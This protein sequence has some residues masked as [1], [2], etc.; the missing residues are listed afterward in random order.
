[1]ISPAVLGS[2]IIEGLRWLCTLG[3][4]WFIL[5]F[6]YVAL[7]SM[8]YPFNLEW[9]EAQTMDVMQRVLDGKPVYAEPA[10]EYVAFIYTP[11]YY[12]VSAFVS[13]LT[14]GVD[15]LPARLVSI[16]STLGCIGLICAWIRKEQGSWHAAIIG[17]GLYMATYRLSGRWFDNARVDSLFMVLTL[18]GLY[19]FYH[20][21]G[22]KAAWLAS[23]LM[24]AGFFTKQAALMMILPLL[25]AMFFVDRRHALLT[26]AITGTLLL[27]GVALYH[28]LSDGWFT[29]FVFE[30]PSGHDI[31][32]PLLWNYWKVDLLPPLGILLVVAV[33]SIVLWGIDEWRRGLCYAALFVGF[34]GASYISR[35]HM[36]G[37]LNVLMP[38]HLALGLVAG[39]SFAYFERRGEHLVLA[40]LSLLLLFQMYGLLY[41][42]K[43]LIPTQKALETGNKFLEELSKIEGE[44]F[45]PELQFVQTRIGQK[46][47][48]LGM[49]AFDVLRS[50]LKNRRNV[51]KKLEKDITDVIV[52]GRFAAIMPGKLVI[53]PR[54][55]F[56]YSYR[57]H[58]EYPQ[59]FI[60]GAINFLRTDLY[61]RK[62]AANLPTPN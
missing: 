58:M 7:S 11:L 20:Y 19:V 16:L 47:Y 54:V 42:P 25:A 24:V 28:L 32:Y 36:Y 17:A 46:S 9:M 50:D 30:V 56:Y 4:L 34:V 40:V 1:M 26:A 52:S 62:P 49:A 27:G 59:E 44:I 33:F 53:L 48:A 41:D 31:A 21:R 22:W 14:G 57:G 2:K 37:Y 29:Y 3:G 45:M 51:K 5:V 39:L 23:I 15:F 13:L 61:Y 10:L 43:P 38:V 35:L 8:S 60:S 6:I 18:G 55:F 12:Y